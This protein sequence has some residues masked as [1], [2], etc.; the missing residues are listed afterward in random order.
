M[1]RVFASL[2]FLCALV[3]PIAAQERYAEVLMDGGERLV[4]RVVEM[5]LDQL[6]LEVAGGTVRLDASKLRSCRFATLEELEREAAEQ[7][8]LRAQQ[9][10]TGCLVQAST[11]GLTLSLTLTL[12]LTLTLAGE[13]ARRA[14]RRPRDHAARPRLRARLDGPPRPRRGRAA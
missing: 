13:Q 4:G 6:A 11:P 10:L 12:T 5:D 3:P 1:L 9:Q 2:L 7:E 14:H 8:A